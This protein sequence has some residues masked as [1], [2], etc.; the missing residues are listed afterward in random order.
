MIS[1]IK[2]AKGKNVDNYIQTQ[3]KT[4]IIGPFLPHKKKWDPHKNSQPV[5][6]SS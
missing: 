3:L 6:K 4:D 1:V 2:N 5:K